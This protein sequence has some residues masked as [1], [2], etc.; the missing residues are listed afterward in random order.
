MAAATAET[1]R[2]EAPVVAAG[3]ATIGY[4]L[5][6]SVSWEATIPVWSGMV[7]AVA[8]AVPA[9]MQIT[10]LSGET[11]VPETLLNPAQQAPAEVHLVA[12]VA[13]QPMV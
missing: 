5:V 12:P 13:V 8:M 9:G 3:Q 1:A 11:A 6:P 10:G 2:A 4:P 7:M